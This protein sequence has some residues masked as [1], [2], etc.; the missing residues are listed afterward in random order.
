[1]I[2]NK[3]VLYA[4]F[5]SLHENL[6]NTLE[7]NRNVAKINANIEKLLNAKT[8]DRDDLESEYISL[9]ASHREMAYIQ[10][11]QDGAKLLHTLLSGN[12]VLR[13]MDTLGC[14]AISIFDAK[15]VNL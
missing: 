7:L 4:T 3:N 14:K 11:L 9:I 6:D 12:A 10:G 1:M 2:D 8:M 5:E 13:V 15:S